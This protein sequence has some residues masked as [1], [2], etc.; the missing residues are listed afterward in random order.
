MSAPITPDPA[1]RLDQIAA[2]VTPAAPTTTPSPIPGVMSREYFRQHAG[3][4]SVT[5]DGKS[6][7]ADAKTP[8]PGKSLGWYAGGKTTLTVGGVRVQVQVGLNL[9]IVKSKEMS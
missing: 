9:T 2:L 8:E 1:L 6:F 5:I 7:D 4:I 3:P